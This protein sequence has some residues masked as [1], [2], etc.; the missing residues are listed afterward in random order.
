MRV[1]HARVFSVN[2]K[3]ESIFAPSSRP[4]RTLA[5]A[6]PERGGPHR[7]EIDP[8]RVRFRAFQVAGTF[9]APAHDGVPQ[10][11]LARRR[12]GARRGGT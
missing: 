6:T 4:A 12:Q 8:P 10:R 2:Q 3:I 9:I 1:R 5:N 11:R 7:P